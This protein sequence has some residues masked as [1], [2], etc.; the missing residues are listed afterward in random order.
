MITIRTL[1]FTDI[2]ALQRLMTELA[3]ASGNPHPLLSKEELAELLKDMELFPEIYCN[4][5]AE[6]DGSAVGFLSLILY[7]T[8]F[9]QG[10][11]ALIN[12][13]VVS[14]PYRSQGV[15]AALIA[16]AEEEARTRGMDELEVATGQEN[17]RAQAFY[18]KCG[19]DGEYI[20]FGMEFSD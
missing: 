5:I 1:S 6:E 4:L 17:H 3:E 11:T 14:K 8:F 12:E 10:G 15:G 19:F 7:K 13:L 9:H 18:R 16:R 20:L 2:E